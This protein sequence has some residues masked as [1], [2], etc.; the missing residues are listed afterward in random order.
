MK[1]ISA[2]VREQQRYTKNQL[3]TCFSYDDVGVEKFIK[4]LKSYG[5]LKTVANTAEQKE[6]TDLIDDD[7]QLMMKLLEMMIATMYSRMS[8][9]L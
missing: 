4:S 3:R 1:I 2:Y 5:I 7:V 6:L 9:S 8:V